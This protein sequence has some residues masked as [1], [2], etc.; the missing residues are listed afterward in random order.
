MRPFLFLLPL[1]FFS[2]CL[3]IFFA[4]P[5]D[6]RSGGWQQIA[7]IDDAGNGAPVELAIAFAPGGQL[8]CVHKGPIA[9]NTAL[10]LQVTPN[11]QNIQDND[12][13]DVTN[14]RMAFSPAGALWISGQT[15]VAGVNIV[16]Y[17]WLHG[18]RS[19]WATNSG[20]GVCYS[21]ITFDDYNYY[22]LVALAAGS[23][24]SLLQYNESEFSPVFT[25]NNAFS[26]NPY[27]SV[28]VFRNYDAHYFLAVNIEDGSGIV[29]GVVGCNASG[30]SSWAVQD[31]AITVNDPGA[32]LP[33]MGFQGSGPVLRA[34]AVTNGSLVFRQHGLE[35][36]GNWDPDYSSALPADYPPIPYEMHMARDPRSGDLY[37][38]ITTDGAVATYKQLSIYRHNGNSW[39]LF[40][41]AAPAPKLEK[42]EMAVHPGDGSVW[43]IGYS[44]ETPDS[45]DWR[46]R[47][48]RYSP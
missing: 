31:P 27:R 38:G 40:A 33:E 26:G 32:P 47:A 41:P 25:T 46:L 8:F 44:P 45:A 6:L 7:V 43:V 1:L 12:L 2:G 28:R 15:N 20:G 35:Y 34:V 9:G 4:P 48:W 39:T 22:P 36:A 17:N 24:L 30:A 10:V 21:D 19:S 13:G 14:I 23:S 11:V 16:I 18:S 29:P 5:M 3:D 42:F 37:L